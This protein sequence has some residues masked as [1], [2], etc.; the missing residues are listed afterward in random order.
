MANPVRDLLKTSEQALSYM[1]RQITHIC[2]D[3]E[4]RAPGSKGERQAAEY[5]AGVLEKDCGCRDIKIEPFRE[6]PSSFYGYFYISAAFGVLG[7]AGF[8]IHPLISLLCCILGELMFLLHFVLYQKVIDPLFPEAESVNVTATWPC[9]G[10]LKQRVFINGHIDA[11]WEFPLN[12]H[13]GGAVF[14]MPGVGSLAGSLFF[15]VL[16][17]CALCGAGPWVHKA[18]LWGLIFVPFFVL[19]GFTYN[20]KRVS[21]GAN[22]NLSGCFMGITLLKE[23]KE[24]GIQLEH[25]EL[26]IIL[27]GS[28][29]AG[30]RGAKAWAKAHKGEFNDVPTYIFCFDTIHDPRYLMV[31]RRDL[32]STIAADAKLCDMFL[33]A[34]KKAGVPCRSGRVPLFGGSTDSAAFTQGGFRSVCITGLNHVLEDYYHT[35]RDTYDNLNEE[36]LMNCYKALIELIDNIETDPDQ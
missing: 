2:R 17:I 29:E 9:S 31:N 25:T 26:G 23:M 24:H 14:E 6:H 22:D 27:N 8:F 4:P 19:H 10:E 18:A 3:M 7:I 15:L 33:E 11:P 12:C 13:F 20:P 1:V 21:D 35:R 30:I 28:E 5:M 16:S 36:G 32:N 34:A